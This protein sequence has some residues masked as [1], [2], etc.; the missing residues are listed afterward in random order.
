MK[1]LRSFFLRLFGVFSRSEQDINSEIEANLQLHV[2]DKVSAGMTV[3][4]ARRDAILTLG[5]IAPAPIAQESR[6]HGH[7]DVDARDRNLR[8]RGHLRVRGRRIAEASAL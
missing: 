3:E 4:E 8:Q 7:G 1:R 2:D 6:V 5:G